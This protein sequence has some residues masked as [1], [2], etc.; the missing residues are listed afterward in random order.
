MWWLRDGCRLYHTLINQLTVSPFDKDAEFLR[1]QIDD[2]VRA[3]VRSQ[4]VVSIA[5]NVLTG[6]LDEPVFDIHINAITDPG[7]R[8]GSPAA[9][10]LHLSIDT[11]VF[12]C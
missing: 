1:R 3:L 2:S 11:S 12:V 10:E 6:G 7:K 5:G 8:F 4:Q 9:G